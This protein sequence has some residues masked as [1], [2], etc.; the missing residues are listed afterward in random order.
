MVYLRNR[1]GRSLTVSIEGDGAETVTV[2]AGAVMP[3][4]LP[5]GSY[6]L[7]IGDSDISGKAR[8]QLRSGV[9]R[10]LDLEEVEETTG[11]RL[12][13]LEVDEG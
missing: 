7:H 2:G 6:Q 13:V 5:P 8:L 11:R 12:Q 9:R 10:L 3:V 4:P 1:S